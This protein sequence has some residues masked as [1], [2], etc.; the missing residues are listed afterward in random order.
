MEHGVSM[1]HLREPPSVLRP[2]ET[3]SE[4]EAIEIAVTKMLL[5]SYYDIVRKN[6]EDSIQKTI[7]H[8]LC[9]EELSSSDEKI[10]RVCLYCMDND[11]IFQ[12]CIWS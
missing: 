4:Q 3:H 1:I 12:R 6:I 9:S 2:S 10:P 11:V 5:R 7:M 8:F